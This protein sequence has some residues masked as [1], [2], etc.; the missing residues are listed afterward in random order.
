MHF[1]TL[2]KHRA[3]NSKEYTAMISVLIKEFENKITE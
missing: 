1:D 3:H 2:A